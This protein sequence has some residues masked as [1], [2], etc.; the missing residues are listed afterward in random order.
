MFV[1]LFY[2]LRQYGVPVS[3]RELLDLNGALQAGV[4]FADREELYRLIRLTMVTPTSTVQYLK[5]RKDHLS[6]LCVYIRLELYYGWLKRLV[7]GY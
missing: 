3:T 6:V 5:T 1:N 4:V 7:P 2:T